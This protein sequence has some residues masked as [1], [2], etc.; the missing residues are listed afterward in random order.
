MVTVHNPTVFCF[1]SRLSF[2]DVASEV[3]SLRHGWFS[4]GLFKKKRKA[5]IDAFKDGK[6]LGDFEYKSIKFSTE[7]FFFLL[8]F[9]CVLL[10]LCLCVW[11]GHVSRRFRFHS[12]SSQLRSVHGDRATRS[13]VCQWPKVQTG[14]HL[15]FGHLGDF[16]DTGHSGRHVFPFDEG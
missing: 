12:D 11:A 16:T 2:W 1:F 3:V 6:Q 15:S 8:L 14:H 13:I 10:R 9:N 4:P 7:V 5:I